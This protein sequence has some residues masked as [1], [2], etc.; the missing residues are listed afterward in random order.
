MFCGTPLRV[1]SRLKNLLLSIGKFEPQNYIFLYTHTHPYM[2]GLA[3][4]HRPDPKCLRLFTWPTS[5][6]WT[7]VEYT[8]H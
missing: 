3:L 2:H 8:S 4:I 6:L 5:I 7:R 1:M